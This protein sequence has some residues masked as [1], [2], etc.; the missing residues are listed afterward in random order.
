VASL[1]VK[2]PVFNKKY[3]EKMYEAYKNVPIQEYRDMRKFK[4][5]PL[6]IQ[7]YYGGYK[8]NKEYIDVSGHCYVRLVSRTKVNKMITD[9]KKYRK[10]REAKS[11][12]IDRRGILDIKDRKAKSY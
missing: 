10:G 11:Y 4:D 12:S 9:D 2:E 6:D 1:T 5:M 3:H 7:E 8:K